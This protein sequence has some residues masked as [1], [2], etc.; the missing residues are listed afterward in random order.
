MNA[1]QTDFVNQQGDIATK[2]RGTQLQ[3]NAQVT[4]LLNNLGMQEA[5]ARKQQEIDQSKTAAK[6]HDEKDMFFNDLSG[7]GKSF[8]EQDVANKEDTEKLKMINT[9]YPDFRGT[10][11]D[12]ATYKSMMSDPNA[13]AADIYVFGQRR[14]ISPKR[15]EKDIKKARGN[16]SKVKKPKTNFNVNYTFMGGKQNK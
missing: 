15:I 10:S 11:D 7:Y 12:L 6:G 13:S 3:Q 14:G 16:K 9:K 1:A 8:L 5:Q 4:Q 2:E